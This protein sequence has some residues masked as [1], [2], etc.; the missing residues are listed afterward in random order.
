MEIKIE[1]IEEK[2]LDEFKKQL[3]PNGEPGAEKLTLAIAQVSAKISAITVQKVFEELSA[4]SQQS[5][6]R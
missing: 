2:V 4:Q 5:S 1:N 3:N 6:D